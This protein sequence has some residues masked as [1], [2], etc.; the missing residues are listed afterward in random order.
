MNARTHALHAGGE[1]MYFLSFFLRLEYNLLLVFVVVEY[2]KN[3][4]AQEHA[5]DTAGII[6]TSQ[7]V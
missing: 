3:S 1:L 7:R 4:L 6:E 5:D 2:S